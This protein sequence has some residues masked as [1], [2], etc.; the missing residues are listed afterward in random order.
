[1][2]ASEDHP[3]IISREFNLPETGVA[4]VIQLLEQGSS[5]PFIA[6]YRKEKTGSIDE[7]GITAV[8]DRNDQ[9]RALQDRKNAILKSLTERELLTR[10]LETAV[11]QAPSLSLL[12]DLYEK[13]RPKKRTRARM[14][15]EKGLA[16]L[17]DALMS[18]PCDSPKKAAGS[19]VSPENGV[20][21][22]EEALAGARD[23]IAEVINED[24]DTRDRVRRLFLR[25]ARIRT[26]RRKGK[27]SEGHKFKDYFD[28]SEPA[29]TTPSHRVLAMFR[30][31]RE[32]VLS[33]HIL[34]EET[35]AIQIME[36]QY[37]QQ[38]KNGWE[39]VREAIKDGYRRL[40][41]KA[42]EKECIH[43]LKAAA[44]ETAI[45]VFAKNLEELLLSSP[46]GQK[47][48]LAIDPGF[49]TGC[50]V[51]VLD[52]Q[53]QLLHH[54]VIFPHQGREQAAGKIITRLI[55]KYQIEAVA[56]GN[57]TAGRETEAFIK[58]LG[59]DKDIQI[60]MVDESGASIYSASE[61]AREEFPD[62][63]ITVR[64]A[65]SIGRRLMDP[66]AEL[67]KLD[68]KS[69]GVGQYQHDVD[70]KQLQKSLD[71][72]VL[73]CV[74]RV[75]VEVNTA[76]RELLARVSGLNRTIAKNIVRFRNDNGPFGS[77]AELHK[78]PRLGPKAFEQ[79]A[80]FLRIHQASNPLDQTGIHPESYP[81]VKQMAKDEGVTVQDLINNKARTER[82]P[83]KNY[84]TD[85]AGLPTLKDI[86]TELQNL[87]RDPRKEFKAFSFDNTIHEITDLAPG[88][89][90]P[91]IVT[92]VT[93]FGAFVDI[94]VHQDGL[95]HISRL[96]D[97]FIKDPNEIVKVRQ[98]VM[99]TIL[100]VDIR[101]QRISLSMKQT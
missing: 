43:K 76:S 16:P 10:E 42:I 33:L 100:D 31:N 6:R 38:R 72:V 30:G 77:R 55:G 67:V 3:H 93:A 54:D 23:I 61:T 92:N 58:N 84:I 94:G 5:I 68:P 60:V 79:C 28:W 9:L 83:L 14:A 40:L 62:Q 12:E 53:G 81:V 89:K 19:F 46:L 37:I 29:F 71:D 90:I 70:P 78:V 41:S 44:D 75:G 1:M 65:V 86:I 36:K 91:G 59:L 20:H 8:R 88:M 15:R 48:T 47:R 25:R 34:P 4:A 96:A 57:G 51:V 7:V 32:G 50:K 35:E 95:V 39:Q 69:I 21:S 45:Q 99:V 74:N 22:E 56:I 11:Y 97:R 13:Y 27:E 49:R 64:G 26:G 63:D 98:A 52:A 17:A 18:S 101:R 87:G 66:L 73:S 24:A 85:S 80:G 82:L 2:I